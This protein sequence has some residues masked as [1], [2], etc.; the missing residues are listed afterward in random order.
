MKVREVMK[1]EVLAISPNNTYEDASRLMLHHKISGLPVVDDNRKV[2]GIIS[3]K[4]LFRALYPS[5]AEFLSNPTSYHHREE[6]EN[7][8]ESLRYTSISQIM[9]KNVV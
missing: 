1:P 5:Y 7:E 4:D 9:T 3:E 8:I 2:V 6:Q